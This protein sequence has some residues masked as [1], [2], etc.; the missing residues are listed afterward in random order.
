MLTYPIGGLQGIYSG[1]CS[2]SIIDHALVAVGYGI[3]STG[4]QYWILRNQWGDTSWGDAGYMYLPI[5][6]DDDV[7]G[8]TCG[9]LGRASGQPPLYPFKVAANVGPPQPPGPASPSSPGAAS[10]PSPIVPSE[11]M[12]HAKH[13]QQIAAS[14]D[15]VSY[16]STQCC[17]A[18]SKVVAIACHQDD[19]FACNAAQLPELA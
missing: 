16:G 9:I 14:H 4:Q 7:T 10:P 17:V 8:G 13:F 15:P 12:V 1:P 3:M 2:S 5:K 11:C 19:E 6:A 18:S